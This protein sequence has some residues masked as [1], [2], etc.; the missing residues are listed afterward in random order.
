MTNILVVNALNGSIPL[1]LRE[2]YPSAKITCAEVFP[3]FKDHLVR[4]G[5]QVVDWDEVGDM[6]FDMVIGNPPYLKGMWQSFIEKACEISNDKV[7]II[8]PNATNNFST[9]SDKF[10]EYLRSN[11]IQNIIDYTSYFPD[12]SSGKIACYMFDKNKASNDVIFEDSSTIGRIFKKMCSID[13]PK[14]S[15]K[16]SSKRSKQFTTATRYDKIAKG[17]IKILENISQ[18]GNKWAYI[19][20]VNASVI[21]GREYWL[22][23]RYYGRSPNDLLIE[24]NETIAISSNILAIKRIDNMSILEFN[25]IYLQPI[26]LKIFEYLR[27]GNSDTSPRH[28][29]LI[30]I[31]TIK[32]PDLY[33]MA[34]LTDNEIAWIETA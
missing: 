2:K 12:I 21:D 16:L 17:R 32:Q 25:S 14:L 9:R 6:K 24:V 26:F 11:G 27:N 20:I 29:N 8:A 19:D 1:V 13:A 22:T 10:V 4:L 31:V 28:I 33:K 3:F 34:N 30:P 5:F 15:A 18:T 7:M 23:N